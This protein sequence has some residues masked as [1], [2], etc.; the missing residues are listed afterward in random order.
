MKNLWDPKAAAQ[1]EENTLQLRVYTSRLLGQNSDLVLHGGGNTSV[2]I[3]QTNL[4]GEAE[5]ILCV[6]GSG[7]N[8]ST[9]DEYGFTPLRLK[10]LRKLAALE[11]LS[12]AEMIRQQ[13]MAMSNP[14]AP[15]PSVEALLHAIIPFNWIDHT[16]ADAVVTITNTPE[17]KELIR[18][19]YGERLLLIPYVMPGFKL[20]RKVFEMTKN[21][22]WTQF[23]GMILLNH[24]I[25][26]FGDS[27]RE[28]YTRMIDLVSLAEEF[29]AT[30][31]SI[32]NTTVPE[33]EKVKTVALDSVPGK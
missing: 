8:L 6:K 31:S 27:A 22:D 11:N 7:N 16:H 32:A 13:Q 5:D 30:N 33:K 23:E 12:D 9:I 20:S 18:K 1:V 3:Q 17:G 25:F 19:I 10:T 28:S 14:D 26:S 4:F 24:G 29:L 21:V 2:K 15:K